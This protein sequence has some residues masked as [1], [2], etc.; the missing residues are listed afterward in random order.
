METILE[1]FA[2]YS[3]ARKS[4][5]SGRVLAIVTAAFHVLVK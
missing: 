2:G 3:F 1:F 5:G 4:L